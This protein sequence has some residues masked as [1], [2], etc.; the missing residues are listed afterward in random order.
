MFLW[1]WVYWGFLVMAL[2]PYGELDADA[3]AAV[4]E[5]AKAAL[6]S[7]GV[8]YVPDPYSAREGE[9]SAKAWKAKH[10]AGPLLEVF[11]HPEGRNPMDPGKFL[12]GF[13]HMAA[14]AFLLALAM[15]K[16]GGCLA[17]YGCRLGL[18]ALVAVVAATWVD[19]G[20]IIWFHHPVKWEAIQW[21]YHAVGLL[22][23][24]AVVAALVKP[25]A[26]SQ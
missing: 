22:L 14:V 23:G 9:D 24:G 6:P 17:K 20:E 10:E 13:L 5:A 8:Y 12:T 18:A 15:R 7:G 19:G 26:A 16:G 2:N 3:E 4:V 11:Y 1:G 21:V 25:V